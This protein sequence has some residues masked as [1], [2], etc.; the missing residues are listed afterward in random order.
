MY[1]IDET[2]KLDVEGNNLIL[3]F[4]LHDKIFFHPN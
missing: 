4:N 1:Y 2:S 3:S